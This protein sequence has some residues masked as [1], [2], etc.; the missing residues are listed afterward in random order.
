MISV[1]IAE[2]ANGGN[3]VYLWE[4][5]RWIYTGIDGVKVATDKGVSLIVKS[6]GSVV[7]LSGACVFCNDEVKALD[8]AIGGGRAFIITDIPED[9][10]NLVYEI[11]EDGTT[12]PLYGF[13]A[14][15]ICVFEG[16]G[17]V[18]PAVL[19][20]DCSMASYFRIEGLWDTWN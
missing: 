8:V 9:G 5:R 7:D 4:N 12:T 2:G 18:V 1:S 3:K 17:V 10:A 20:K 11:F 15:F 6:D 19:K 14:D 13:G 16:M